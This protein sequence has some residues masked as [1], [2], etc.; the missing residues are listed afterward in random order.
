VVVD[1]TV[2]VLPDGAVVVVTDGVVVVVDRTVVVVTDGAVVVV[3]GG[4]VVVV[5]VD[6]EPHCGPLL[7]SITCRQTP[8]PSQT[9]S[10]HRLRS[11]VQRVPGGSTHRSVSSWQPLHSPPAHG[12]PL[13]SVQ[14]PFRHVSLPLQNRPSSHGMPS[15][16]MTQV[17]GAPVQRAHS[18][19]RHSAL[20][21]S[22]PAPLPSSHSSSASMA[23]SPQL[24]VLSPLRQRV[25]QSPTLGGSHCSPL[26]GSTNPSPQ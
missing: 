6:A 24:A 17:E 14:R 15:G 21:P 20:Q 19:T 4:A 12:S 18:S 1:E 8:A 9:S 16:S 2:V 10:V 13:W 3:T 26:P 11:S 5:V 22:P 25:S 7:G 23:P